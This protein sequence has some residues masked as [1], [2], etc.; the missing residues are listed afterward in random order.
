MGELPFI[1]R[2][3]V[4]AREDISV[5]V[6]R[7]ETSGACAGWRLGRCDGR[8]SVTVHL[9]VLLIDSRPLPYI[10]RCGQADVARVRASNSGLIE[11][12]SAD[13]LCTRVRVVKPPRMLQP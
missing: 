4:D 7:G 10:I 11:C 1:P 9:R 6:L 2:A 3:D 8:R 12:F 5:V 13:I